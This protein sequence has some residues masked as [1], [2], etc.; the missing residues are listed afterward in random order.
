M[1][2]EAGLPY[3]ATFP[4]R[5]QETMAEQKKRTGVFTFFRQVRQEGNKVT[6]T[7]RQE[8]LAATVMVLIMVILAGL[9]LFLADTIFGT[10]VP[11]IQGL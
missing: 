6:W 8:T 4:N 5:V 2:A 1:D 9:F 7:S 3:P 11:M 10:V